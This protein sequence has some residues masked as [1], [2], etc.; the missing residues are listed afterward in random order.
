MYRVF[1]VDDRPLVRA[2]LRALLASDP[3][4]E[5]VGEA[6]SLAAAARAFTRP[7]A[8]LAPYALVADELESTPLVGVLILLEVPALAGG[9]ALARSAARLDRQAS[10]DQIR[11][12]IVATC[13]GD[14]QV[15]PAPPPP[16]R[17]GGL[18]PRE[19]EVMRALA[20]GRTNREIAAELGISVKTI[21][22]HRGHVLKKRGLRNNADLTRYAIRNGF[23]PP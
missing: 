10:L 9:A 15:T 16:A 2:A 14:D 23:L 21:D 4:L 13:G 3:E 6:P 7:G 12:A 1:L 11:S 8:L 17:E 19:L 22:T 18:S 20:A 5:V